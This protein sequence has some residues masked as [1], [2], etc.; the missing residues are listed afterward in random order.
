[1]EETGKIK[2]LKAYLRKPQVKSVLLAFFT[3]VIGALCSSFGGWEI[4]DPTIFWIKIGALVVFVVL[5]AILLIFYATAEVNDRRTL[6][7]R[8]KQIHALEAALSS[9]MALCNNNSSD[10]KAHLQRIREKGK[11]DASLW[12]FDSACKSLCASVYKN[13]CDLSGSKEFGVAYVRLDEGTPQANEVYMNSY[14]NETMR[15]PSIHKVRRRIDSHDPNN[16]HDIDLFQK[17]KA[18][19]E[20]LIGKDEIDR[21]FSYASKNE[22]ANNRNKYNQYIGIPVFCDDEKM[23]GLLEIVALR[24]ACLGMNKSEAEELVKKFIAPY[25]FLFLL[26]YTMDSALVLTETAKP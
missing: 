5:Y 21:A 18:D 6:G 12:S 3:I 14:A 17:G 20:V 4:K 7:E 24:S 9:M 26:L 22:R 13:I 15:K 19:I 10:I 1:M 11:I 16:Y 8:E 25:A 2:K 23:V